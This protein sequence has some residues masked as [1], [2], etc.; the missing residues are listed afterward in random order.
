MLETTPFVARKSKFMK[1]TSLLLHYNQQNQLYCTRLN[2]WVYVLEQWAFRLP[3][4]RQSEQPRQQ[5][6]NF[7]K[8]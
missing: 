8:R 7:N 3:V 6:A 2:K 1:E 4:S 5:K